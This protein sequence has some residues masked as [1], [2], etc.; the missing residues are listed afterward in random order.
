MKVSISHPKINFGGTAKDQRESVIYDDY[1][2]EGWK[3][4]GKTIA[5]INI[6]AHDKEV[7]GIVL[8][9]QP[10]TILPSDSI[11]LPCPPFCGKGFDEYGD[12]NQEGA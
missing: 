5:H 1:A 4:Q 8:Q 10:K 12:E 9:S 11:L 6:I 7:V 2:I 3:A